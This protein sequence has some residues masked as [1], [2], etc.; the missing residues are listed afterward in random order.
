MASTRGVV[1]LPAAGTFTQTTIET[2]IT[3]ESNQLWAITGLKGIMRSRDSTGVEVPESNVVDLILSTRATT[4][5]LPSESEE[6]ARVSWA[7]AFSTAVG[8]SQVELV[9]QITLIEPRVTAQPYLYA[10][11]KGS[12]TIGTI[13][14]IY[15]EVYYEQV[16]T[17]TTTLLQLMVGGA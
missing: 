10:G 16:K 7:L 3:T 14:D 6:I 17:N 15:F 5:T 9:K 12:T 2:M 8:F 4:V 1:V 13:T 11:V